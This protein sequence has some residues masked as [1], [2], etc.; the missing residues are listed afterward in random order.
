M[1]SRISK[2]LSSRRVSRK[3]LIYYQVSI[4]VLAFIVVSIYMPF[5]STLNCSCP[6]P[7]FSLSLIF[8]PV[9]FLPPASPP[10]CFYMCNQVLSFPP[11]W[12]SIPP[13]PQFVTYKYIDTHMYMMHI[14]MQERVKG[15]PH[16]WEN[17]WYLSFGDWLVSFNIV[18]SSYIHCLTNT[19]IVFFLMAL[20]LK[21]LCSA[22][23]I[24][25]SQHLEANR[26]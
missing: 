17:T 24:F 4:H 12:K 14:H 20:R 1:F 5:S 15:N 19:M 11:L 22:W 26:T 23:H 18:I 9:P 21:F 10:F 3:C 13:L 7:I 6:L 8:Q 2:M 16:M 25:M